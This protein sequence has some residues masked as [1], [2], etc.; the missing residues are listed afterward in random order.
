[1]LKRTTVIMKKCF[2]FLKFG[3]LRL[4]MTDMR[5]LMLLTVVQAR[6]VVG[7]LVALVLVEELK[8]AMDKDVTLNFFSFY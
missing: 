3:F 7:L 8:A 6:W 5:L 4:R 1:M 2:H